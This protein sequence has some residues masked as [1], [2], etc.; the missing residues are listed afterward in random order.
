MA[1]C[2][3]KQITERGHVLIKKPGKMRWDYTAPEK[4]LF[5]SDGVGS[6]S[7]VPEDK[8]VVVSS[9]P[10]DAKAGAPPCFSRARAP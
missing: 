2:S 7:Y 6:I 9:V 3:G 5:V 8:Q 4:K 10:P 1:A